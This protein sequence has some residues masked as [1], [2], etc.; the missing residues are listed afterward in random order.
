MYNKDEIFQYLETLQQSGVTNMIGIGA[1]LEVEFG[2]TSREASSW[3][4][5]WINSF[6]K[7]NCEN[8]E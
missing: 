6:N 4:G 8:C 5:D 1:Y 7:N 2:M 3:L